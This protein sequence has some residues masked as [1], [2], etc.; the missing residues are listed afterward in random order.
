MSVIKDGD[1]DASET[2]TQKGMSRNRKKGKTKRFLLPT[3]LPLS[4]CLCFFASASS[5]VTI[6][7]CG[8]VAQ[9]PASRLFDTH[10]TPRGFGC[11]PSRYLNA[12]QEDG[13][14]PIFSHF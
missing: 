1:E 8:R 14:G 13:V 3:V 4:C 7:A 5:H 6:C 2:I 10:S 12:H 11:L 9:F